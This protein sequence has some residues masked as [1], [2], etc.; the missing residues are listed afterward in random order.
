MRAKEITAA[1]EEYLYCQGQV[2]GKALGRV[3]IEI[4]IKRRKQRDVRYY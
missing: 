3:I 4:Y 2:E 1:S